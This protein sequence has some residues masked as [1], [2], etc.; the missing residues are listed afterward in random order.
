MNTLTWEFQGQT[1]TTPPVAVDNLLNTAQTKIPRAIMAKIR[2]QQDPDY[3][4]RM[5][6]ARIELAN[7][8]CDTNSL[9]SLRLRKGLSQSA[10]AEMI[11]TTQPHIAKIEAKQICPKTITCRNM[12]QA[13]GV[14]FEELSQCIK[15]EE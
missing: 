2:E 10:L 9:A 6:K 8:I 5:K 3:R 11:G 1:E 7:D 15:L 14:T 12:A 4:A 13:L